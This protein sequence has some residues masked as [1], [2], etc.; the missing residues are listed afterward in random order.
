MLS[1]KKIYFIDPIIAK[2]VGFKISDDF[3]RVLENIVFLELKR[4]DF[5]IF[6]HR[7]LKECDFIIRKS[8]KT[9]QAIQVSKGISEIKT[10]QRE[11]DGLIEALKRFSLTEGLIITE[12]EEFIENVEKEGQIFKINVVPIWKWL[13]TQHSMK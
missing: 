10:R 6:Y 5:E 11:I 7:E 1:P 8:P 4:R 12:N 2:T 13:L 9:L 3:G